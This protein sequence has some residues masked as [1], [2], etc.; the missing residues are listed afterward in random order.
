ME[1]EEGYG[2]EGGSGVVVWMGVTGG[3]RPGKGEG[4]ALR[5][6]RVYINNL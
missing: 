3:M 4:R 6:K 5:S 1:G 2:E